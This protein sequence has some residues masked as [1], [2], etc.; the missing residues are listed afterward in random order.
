MLIDAL[1]RHFNRRRR[2]RVRLAAGRHRIALEDGASGRHC[3]G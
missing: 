3:A 2:R 1:G